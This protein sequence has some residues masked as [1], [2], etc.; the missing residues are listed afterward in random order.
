MVTIADDLGVVADGVGVDSKGGVV[1][2]GAA[3]D[4]FAVGEHLLGDLVVVEELALGVL[5]GLHFYVII[6]IGIEAGHDYS[7]P[8]LLLYSANILF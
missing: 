2:E 6:E 7:P 8:C 5:A 3:V 1:C 4:Q